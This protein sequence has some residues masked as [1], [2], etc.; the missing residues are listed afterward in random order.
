M[1]VHWPEIWLTSGVSIIV[2]IPLPSSE[3]STSS[4]DFDSDQIRFLFDWGDG[5]TS[6]TEYYP[7][8]EKVTESYTWINEGS[9]HVKVRAQDDTGVWSEWS[10]SLPITIPKNKLHSILNGQEIFKILCQRFPFIF[11]LIS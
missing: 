9:F 4:F 6:I 5:K 8:E 7:S 11:R 10:D 3:F 2:I 1:F